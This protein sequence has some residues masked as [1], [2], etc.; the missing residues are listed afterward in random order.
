VPKATKAST[1]VTTGSSVERI[2]AVDGPTRERPAKKRPT[3]PTVDTTAIAAI[4]PSP[5]LLSA[6]RSSPPPAR[7]ANVSIAAAPVHTKVLSASA[8]TRAA[9]PSET[10]M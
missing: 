3:A 2:E 5:S 4:Q 1:T 7:P 10:K 9:T 6:P 8:P